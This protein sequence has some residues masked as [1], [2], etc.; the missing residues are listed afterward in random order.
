MALKILLS[1]SEVALKKALGSDALVSSIPEEKGA[2]ILL[3]SKMGSMGMQR[4]EWQE[5]HHSY[6]I[7]VHSDALSVKVNS[8]IG[9][10]VLFI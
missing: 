5:Q 9:L 4:K 8:N 1:P 3:F 10:M 6:R 7:I 2:D